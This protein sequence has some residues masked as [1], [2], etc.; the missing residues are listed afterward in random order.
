MFFI[1]FHGVPNQHAVDV[2]GIAGA[3]INCY[4]DAVDLISA[5]K[6]A[7]KDISKMNWIVLNR[8]EA[9]K[10]DDTTISDK[11]R[12][13]YNQALIDKTVYVFHTYPFE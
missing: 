8:E 3:Y 11:G 12:K 9:Y 1:M 13:Y 4:I 6:I 7:K 5:T 2:D 10:I